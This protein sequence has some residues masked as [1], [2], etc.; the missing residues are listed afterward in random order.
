MT[1]HIEKCFSP[2]NLKEFSGK[3]FV[4]EDKTK[5]FHSHK[6][7]QIIFVSAGSI[8]IYIENDMI[9][10]ANTVIFLPSYIPHK[11]VY[12][13][14]AIT[15]ILFFNSNLFS[16]PES[17]LIVSANPLLKA[18]II[19]ASNIHQNKTGTWS[20]TS[21]DNPLL[22]LI[23]QELQEAKHMPFMQITI[24]QDKRLVKVI[25]Y[26]ESRLSE[27]CNLNAIC[28]ACGISDRHLTR[29]FKKETGISFSLWRQH[30]KLMHAINILQHSKSTTLAAQQLGFSSDSSFIHF[31]KKISGHTPSYFY[32]EK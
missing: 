19:K 28:A 13:K 29:L 21:P 15:H 20:N 3:T 22:Q 18:L 32:K 12:N 7:A 11:V 6:A 5:D 10:G 2:D 9:L 1:I 8:E 4:Q 31:F 16:V 30:F 27:S 14:R 17:R 23:L 26:L 24:P 25:T